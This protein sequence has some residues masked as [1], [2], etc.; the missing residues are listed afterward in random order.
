MQLKKYC[1]KLCLSVVFISMLSVNSWAQQDIEKS[2]ATIKKIADLSQGKAQYPKDSTDLVQIKR[3]TIE[4]WQKAIS[5]SPLYFQDQIRLQD[6][7]RVRIGVNQPF[8]EWKFVGVAETLTENLVRL[9]EQGVYEIYQDSKDSKT[10][11]IRV[12]KGASVI[13][14]IKGTIEVTTGNIRSIMGSKALFS[15]NPDSS[16]LI[17]LEKGKMTFPEHPDADSLKPGQMLMFD[18]N[19]TVRIIIPGLAAVA[20]LN[21]FIKFNNSRIWKAPIWKKPL[22]W[23]VIAV[24]P[25]IFIIFPPGGKNLPGPPGVSQGN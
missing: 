12:V 9:K 24:P 19:G 14:T 18:R 22:F 1:G 16:G 2:V 13:E 11:S 6:S 25:I 5:N 21:N 3:N 15:V 10:I 8:Q 17:Y 4:N 7:T 20:T 23:G